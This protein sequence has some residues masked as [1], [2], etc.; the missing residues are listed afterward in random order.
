M[1]IYYKCNEDKIAIINV[2]DVEYLLLNAYKTVPCV[3]ALN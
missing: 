3:V 1:I 2:F